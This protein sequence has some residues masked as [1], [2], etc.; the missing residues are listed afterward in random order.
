MLSTNRA[1]VLTVLREKGQPRTDDRS[2]SPEALCVSLAKDQTEGKQPLKQVTS[3]DRI[4]NRG[5]ANH[6]VIFVD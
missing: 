3:A 5:N 1:L 2:Q 4:N 6:P